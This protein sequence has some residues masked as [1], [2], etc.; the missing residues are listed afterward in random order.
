MAGTGDVSIIIQPMG[1]VDRILVSGAAKRLASTLPLDATVTW[2]LWQLQPPQSA[3][4]W[5]RMQYNADLVN[6]YVERFYHGY[7][8][9][10]RRLVAAIVNSDGYVGN[11]NF[12]FGLAQP[13]TGVASVYTVRL[14]DEDGRLFF[15]RLVKE[16]TH[17]VMHLLGLV[18]CPNRDCVMSFSNSVLDVDRKSSRLCSECE[19]KLARSRIV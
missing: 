12:V 2:S 19:L 15:E 18:H 8:R 6:K 10:G 11:L 9:R 13:E 14:Q 7:L 16:V 5:R 17:E 3:F 4:N 1:G